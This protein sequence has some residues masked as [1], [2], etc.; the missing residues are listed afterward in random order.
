MCIKEK[1]GCCILSINK[2][3]RDW[4]I[5]LMIEHLFIKHKALGSTGVH[6]S[7]YTEV[8]TGHPMSSFFIHSFE[9]VLLPESGVVFS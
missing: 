6:M 8:R 1:E 2:M 7:M 5:L 4:E 3:S 9:A